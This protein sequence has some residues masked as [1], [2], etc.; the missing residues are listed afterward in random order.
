[1]DQTQTKCSSQAKKPIAR[2]PIGLWKCKERETDLKKRKEMKE[3]KTTANPNKSSCT[4]LMSA[5][6]QEK[7]DL[8]PISTATE[9][10]CVPTTFFE[11][12]SNSK[13]WVL[14]IC[15]NTPCCYFWTWMEAEFTHPLGMLWIV[16]YRLL[17]KFIWWLPHY[18]C[19][20]TNGKGMGR[21]GVHLY[22]DILAYTLFQWIEFVW[23]DRYIVTLCGVSCLSCSNLIQWWSWR[24]FYKCALNKFQLQKVWSLYIHDPA[25]NCIHY[26][27]TA[28][29]KFLQW[30]S[31][32]A[33]WIWW[34]DIY[35]QLQPRFCFS[36]HLFALTLHNMYT[37]QRK[38]PR[39]NSRWVL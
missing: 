3:K 17:N 6:G 16:H 29:K 28:A 13:S 25:N 12:C 22:I 11:T 1:M 26:A 18:T 31:S 37:L 36:D 10:D 5:F 23:L 19:M 20:Y 38:L 30:R 4:I 33:V 7:G 21:S 2:W 15:L 14:S 24:C 35:N 32:V 34:I 9:A 27:T 39:C 8:N